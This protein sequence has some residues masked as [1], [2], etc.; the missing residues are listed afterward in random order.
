[1]AGCSSRHRGWSAMMPRSRQ[2]SIS[3]APIGRRRISAAIC[4]VVGRR[5]RNGSGSS[6]GSAFRR[7]AFGA[8]CDGARGGQGFGSGR[9]AL[10]RKSRFERVGAEQGD[11]NARQDQRDVACT[12]ARRGAGGAV[13]E[14]ARLERGGEFLAVVD[15]LADEAKQAGE[16]AAPV[17]ARRPGARRGCGVKGVGCGWHER[18]KA[19]NGGEWQ[20]KYSGT[21]RPIWFQR[22][23]PPPSRQTA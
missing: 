3:T 7:A 22:L 19:M 9:A 8:R 13:G 10:R 12:E 5:A 6:S 11:G 2:I 16:T 4:A 23:L 18:N 1:M 20:G 21:P 17:G 14:A 15:E